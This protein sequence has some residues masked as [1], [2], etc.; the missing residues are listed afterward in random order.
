MTDQL[1]KT[2]DPCGEL[3]ILVEQ[4]NRGLVLAPDLGEPYCWVVDGSNA[5]FRGEFAQLD[6]LAE[7]ARCGGTAQAV[8]LFRAGK[9]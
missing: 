5:M 9:P 4:W 2:K 3:L 7:A 6:A 1:P 8:P